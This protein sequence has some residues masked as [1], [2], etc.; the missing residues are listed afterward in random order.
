[1][2]NTRS[3]PSSWLELVRSLS[4]QYG[5]VNGRSSCAGGMGHDL[6]LGDTGRAMAVAGADAVAAG[7][8]A[9]DDDDMLARR[10]CSCPLSLSPATTLF[11]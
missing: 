3:Q 1:M 2:A 10:R 9:T 7:I 5:H 4:G 6:E 8:A 11:C